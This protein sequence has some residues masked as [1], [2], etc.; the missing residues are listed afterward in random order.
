MLGLWGQVVLVFSPVH[1]LEA[2]LLLPDF[3]RPVCLHEYAH[4]KMFLKT[5]PYF[6]KETF[7]TCNFQGT[8]FIS[9]FFGAGRITL[10][11]RIVLPSFPWFPMDLES[12]KEKNTLFNNCSCRDKSSS[13]L[14]T[15]QDCLDSHPWPSH[16]N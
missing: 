15:P 7:L 14:T 9:R 12:R 6:M 8:I 11:Y 3:H 5:I 10:L 1:G 13:E 4:E 2:L 16:G